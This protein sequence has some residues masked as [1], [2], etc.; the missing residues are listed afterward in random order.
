MGGAQR[1]RAHGGVHDIGARLDALEDGHGGQTR[2]VMAVHVH[3]DADGLL[4]LLHQ[5]IGGVG[6]E[7]AG[8]VLDADGV[9]AHLLQRLGILAEILVV[10]HRAEGVAD[11]ALHMGLFLDGRLDGSLQVAGV[12]QGVEDAQDVDAVLDGKLHELLHHVVMVVLV[13]QQVLA[14]QEHLQ[15][16]VGHVLADVAQALPGILAQVAQAGVEGGTAPAL[17]GVVAGLIHFGQD[18]F[19]IG[20]GQAG[21][22]QGLVGITQNGFSKL[23]LFQCV[24][25]SRLICDA[26]DAARIYGERP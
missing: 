21:G 18:G 17:H 7:Q 8:H 22:H 24:Y 23:D 9:D 15:L 25:T 13:A 16:G 4:Q 26:A 20:V 12:V 2:G 19:I 5:L 1:Q 6:L 10:M 11:A 14:A 3:G